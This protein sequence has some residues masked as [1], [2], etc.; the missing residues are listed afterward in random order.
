MQS[1]TRR[2][3]IFDGVCNLCN[4]WVDF[5]MR[6]DP[7]ARFQF[8]ANQSEAGKE[9]LH[10][11]GVG[12][13]EVGTIYFIEGDQLYS[14]STAV[15]RLLKAL[16]GVYALGY[17]AMIIPRAIRDAVY[18]LIARNRYRFFGQK[19]TCRIPTSAERSRF[20]V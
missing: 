4:G 3:I 7:Q 15:L 19:D 8:S 1:P 10:E 18:G 20:L 2:V 14:Q 11:F 12:T 13:E 6:R 9:M 17:A 5:V 16:G